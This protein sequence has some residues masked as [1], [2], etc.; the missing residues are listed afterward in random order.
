MKFKHVITI[1]LLIIFLPP[2]AAFSGEWVPMNSGT[3]NQLEGIWGS[4]GADVFA[5]G[6]YG[7][8]LHY[9]GSV[10]S[11]MT[12]GTSQTLFE[13]WGS[14]G[15]DVFAVGRDGTILHYDGSTWSSMS[16]GTTSHLYTIWGS[17]AADVFA[18]GQSG[19]ILHYDGSVWSSMDSALAGA[20]ND[21]W[22]SSSTDVFAVGQGGY[23]LYYNGISWSSMGGGNFKNL[24]GVWG[25]SGSDVFAVGDSGAIQHFDGSMW[26]GLDEGN[27]ME[28][29]YQTV[30]G[31]TAG[32]VYIA[33]LA[34]MYHFNGSAWEFALCI[35]SFYMFS[36]WGSSA[37]DIFSVG[38]DGI[39]YHYSDDSDNDGIPNESDNCKYTPNPDQTDADGDG[40]GD[41]CDNCP[42]VNN[43][44]QFDFDFDGAGN[45]CED[46]DGDGLNDDV[47]NC[48]SVFNPGQEDSDGDGYGDVCDSGSRFIVADQ[49]TKEVFIFDLDG[50]LINKTDFSKLGDLYFIRDA[51]TSG[52]LLKGLGNNTW[53]ICHVDSSG[54]L[55][56][57][58]TG[59]PVGPGP[60]YS[61]LENGN[62]VVNNKDTGDIYLY[63]ASGV[64]I[65]STNAWTDPN[66]WS[67]TFTLMGDIA[68]L[69]GGE[70]VVLPE[71]GTAD[72]GGPGFTPY[73]Y[74]YDDNLNLVNKVDI[75]PYHIT[76]YM[77]AGLSSGG[78]VGIGNADGSN[79]DT[80][81]FYFDAS[82]VLTS[83]RNITED[84]PD[85]GINDYMQYAISSTDDGGVIVTHLYASQVWIFHSP[86][87][88]LDLS[89][90]GISSIGGIGG[91]Y[92]QQNQAPQCPIV[93]LLGNDSLKTNTLRNLRDHIMV[94]SAVGKEYAR[95]FH[96]H[97]GELTSIML[98]DKKIEFGS[99]KL[100]NRLWPSIG[101][102]LKGEKIVVRREMLREI[103]A[104]LDAFS[105]KASPALKETINKIRND[106]NH[107]K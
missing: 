103:N 21:L 64:P 58:F 63:S 43:P 55:R 59:L 60:Y 45:V 24:Y 86:P 40:V 44:D 104:V 69:T 67:T 70:V 10:W 5:V 19:T 61:G 50:N 87:V 26:S 12:S 89:S 20:I 56:G 107:R 91:S 105:S 49:K 37:S 96:K 62:F 39:I 74:F 98:S 72:A 7:T 52:W 73:L 84:I 93:T 79:I 32:D 33:G 17:S 106:L 3:T 36:M 77:L 92:F 95:L 11:P 101:L 66:G 27:P 68:G 94:K 51:G 100:I 82:G 35:P 85:I 31:S 15:S 75:A 4:S 28:I 102:L 2:I 76:V 97:S 9:D 25:S 80:H 99:E 81:L 38:S 48:P 13:V 42:S 41:A 83:Q 14:S 57:V 88:E 29:Y 30:W 65:K 16:S 46:S 23:I 78:F 90:K 18:A 1:L 47:D 8:I 6:D 34:F 54:A 22:G 53:K 71:L